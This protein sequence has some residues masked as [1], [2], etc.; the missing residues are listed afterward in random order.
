MSKLPDEVKEPHL[1]LFDCDGTLTDSHAAIVKAMQQAFV[2]TG[3][4]APGDGAVDGVIG[5]SL[6]AAVEA[7][8]SDLSC[9]ERIVEAYRQ[10]YSAAEA[11]LS[12]YPGVTET[13]D[14]L[15]RRGY[16][17]GIVTGKSKPGLIRVLKQF[18]LAGYFL[19]LRTADCCLSKPHPAMALECMDELGVL[20]ERTTL[21]GDAIFDMQ[22]AASANLRAVGV[23]FGV[24]PAEILYAQGAVDVVDDFPALLAHFPPLM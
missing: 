13:L 9:N 15:Q 3:L 19:V 18:D 21:V 7:L 12:L 2:A 10:Y 20:P 6:K 4:P 14:E 24:E 1:I 22:M 8:S 16:W 23:S 11:S 17:M 5:L